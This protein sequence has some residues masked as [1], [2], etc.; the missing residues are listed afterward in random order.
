M[1]NLQSTQADKRASA[2]ANGDCASLA[3]YARV[4]GFREDS[5]LL[6]KKIKADSQIPLLSVAADAK[7]FMADEK[8]SDASKRL[9]L[10]DTTASRIY[11]AAIRNRYNI[12]LPDEFGAPLL[13]V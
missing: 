1:A 6:L 3:P 9:L 7:N 11:N 2:S 10:L 13:K 8:I 4:L 12:T 5:A